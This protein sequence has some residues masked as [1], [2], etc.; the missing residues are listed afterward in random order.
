M[1]VPGAP[2]EPSVRRGRDA[3]LLLLL[4]LPCLDA[5]LVGLLLALAL[6]VDHEAADQADAGA[7]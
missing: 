4:L 1:Q 7:D 5:P 3:R 2:I 6:L